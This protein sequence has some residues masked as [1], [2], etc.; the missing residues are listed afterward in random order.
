M[1]L[2]GLHSN[3]QD[4]VS[5]QT[6]GLGKYRILKDKDYDVLGNKVNAQFNI[7]DVQWSKTV[8]K[9]K[10]EADKEASLNTAA[11]RTNEAKEK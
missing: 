9:N 1:K 10:L 5:N 4:Q 7:W 8:T 11:E 2:Q 6:Y 3:E